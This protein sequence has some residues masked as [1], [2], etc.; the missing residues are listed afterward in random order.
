MGREKILVIYFTAHA[1][2][3][4][5]LAGRAARSYT[6]SV[7]IGRAGRHVRHDAAVPAI[8]GRRGE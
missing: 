3:I 5:R 6:E 7:A 4:W 8:S 1:L 2:S